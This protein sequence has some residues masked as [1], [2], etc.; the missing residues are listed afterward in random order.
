MM[1]LAALRKVELVARRD[2]TLGTIIDR[3]AGV[4]GDRR[5]VEQADGGLRCSYAQAA[6]RVNR[7]AGGISHYAQPGDRVVIATSNGYEQFLLALAASRAGCIPVPINPQMTDDEIRHVIAD[8]GAG[9]VVRSVNQ[10][11][12]SVPLTTPHPARPDDLAALFYTSGTTGKPKGVELTHQA[13]VGQ[14]LRGVLYPSRLRRDEAVISLPIAHIMG[15]VTLLGLAVAG[16]PVHFIPSFRPD[17]VLRAIAERRATLFIGVPAMYRMM[18][19]AGA[20][21][22]D[23]SSVRVWGSGAD[24]MPV[25]LALQFKRMGATASLPIIGGVGEALFAEGYG[26][27]EVGGGVA[28]K[29]SPP[30]LNLGLGESLGFPLPS[31]RMR[32]VDED[33]LDVGAGDVGELWIRGPGV[34]RGYWNAPEATQ[35][36]VTDDG[37]LRTGDLA[38]KGPFG[39]VLFVGRQKD[40]IIRGGYTVYSLEVQDALEAHPDVVEAAVTALPDQRMGEVPGA[41]VRLA[42]GSSLTAEGLQ[43][44]ATQHLAEYKVPARVLVVGELPRTGTNKVQRAA[45]LALFD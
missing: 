29:V 9:Y 16:I 15:F 38:R 24:V 18:L 39:S 28:A 1:P 32:V 26:M 5:L 35:Q 43:A 6:K 37:W 12:G 27:V 17:E 21:T 23:L 4:H 30:M 41:A 10:V 40:V 19:E 14:V 3:L 34:L 25:D 11:D 45:L 44:W 8:S 36:A 31:Y 13:L 2:A 7:W 33:G 42:E 22:Y 20:E